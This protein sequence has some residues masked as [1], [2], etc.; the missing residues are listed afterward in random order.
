MRLKGNE[1]SILGD[2]GEHWL[3]VCA[4]GVNL[5][6]GSP[7]SRDLIRADVSV[8]YDG[9]AWGTS[10]PS[11]WVQVKT[12]QNAR[13]GEDDSL[14]FDLDV[15]TYNVLRRTDS[16]TRRLLLV[17]KVSDLDEKIQ[18]APDGTLLRG[19]ARW[20]SIEGWPETFNTESVAVRLPGENRVD[21]QGLLR[22]LEEYG[23]RRSTPVP[24][25]DGW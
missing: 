25:I 3:R 21:Q 22:M 19:T 13:E 7:D 1:S 6:H 10:N 18:L 20:V 15:E 17:V 9:S 12:T 11:V 2:F 16:H 24:E 14:T 4:S 5:L 23:T 8:T